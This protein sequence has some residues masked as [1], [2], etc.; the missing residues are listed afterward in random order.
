MTSLGSRKAS[1]TSVTRFRISGRSL[2]KIGKR[3]FLVLFP[4]NELADY[5]QYYIAEIAYQQS[6]FE[7]AAT[8]YTLLI[9][10]YLRSK[11]IVNAQYKL[12]LCYLKMNEPTRA[13]ACFNQVIQQYPNTEEA[14]L[15]HSRLQ[16]LAE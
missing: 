7:R 8:E 10:R 5:C 12:G 16:E 6:D 4:Q 9:D 1:T 3:T 15:S 13:S 11:K 14:L 2:R